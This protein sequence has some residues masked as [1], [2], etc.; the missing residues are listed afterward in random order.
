MSKSQYAKHQG[1]SEG[2]GSS[3]AP[4][5]DPAGA[6]TVPTVSSE[7]GSKLHPTLTGK[8]GAPLPSPAAVPSNHR[9]GYEFKPIPRK[10]N[11]KEIAQWFGVFDRAYNYWIRDF[12]PF[13]TGQKFQV[14]LPDVKHMR[15]LH[16]G[17]DVPVP[18]GSAWEKTLAMAVEETEVKPIFTIHAPHTL[19]FYGWEAPLPLEEYMRIHYEELSK[20]KQRLF[21]VLTPRLDFRRETMQGLIKIGIAGVNSSHGKAIGRLRQYLIAYGTQE[22]GNPYSGVDVWY[23]HAQKWTN[24]VEPSKT[25]IHKLEL[26]IKRLLKENNYLKKGRGSERS[27]VSIQQLR[28]WLDVLITTPLDSM[29]D[30]TV[31]LMCKTKAQKKKPAC[32]ALAKEQEGWYEDEE[33]EALEI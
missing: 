32:I 31:G 5:T 12:E 22:P 23:I 11:Y 8:K 6:T 26:R 9:G 16:T 19:D 15:V 10:M 27:T 33:V 29:Q 7:A 13:G 25:R 14:F 18:E 3:D 1:H 4:P 28:E 24:D 2:G 20:N 30:E 17:T 21:Y